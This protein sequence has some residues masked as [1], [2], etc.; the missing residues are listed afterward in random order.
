M[1]LGCNS[2]GPESVWATE[3]TPGAALCD[4]DEL[5]AEVKKLIQEGY[6]PIVTFQQVEHDYY[7]VPTIQFAAFY[8]LAQAG[9]TIV[10]GS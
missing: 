2:V 4:Y 10:S 3:E 1:F 9:A 6:F 5:I 7:S 8:H